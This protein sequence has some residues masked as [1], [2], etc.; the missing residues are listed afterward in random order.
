M[1][2]HPKMLSSL[3]SACLIAPFSASA[4]STCVAV[5][6]LAYCRALWPTC[7]DTTNPAHRQCQQF[8]GPDTIQKQ[9]SIG[10]Y[11]NPP[12]RPATS[13]SLFQDSAS[14][15]ARRTC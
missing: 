9:T 4:Q 15:T 8:G 6:K 12:G 5:E 11:T 7:N 10:R 2:A 1:K 3:V 13:C 14:E